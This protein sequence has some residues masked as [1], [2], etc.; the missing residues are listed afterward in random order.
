MKKFEH[1]GKSLTKVQQ[2]KINGGNVA[3]ISCGGGETL[4]A[5]SRNWTC[6]SVGYGS[7]QCGNMSTMEV[8]TYSCHD[9]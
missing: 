9:E 7:I 1:L 6:R 3:C 4:C 5:G 2:K 8:K